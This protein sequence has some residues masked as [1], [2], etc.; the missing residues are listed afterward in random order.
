MRHGFVLAVVS[1]F[2]L[3]SDATAWAAAGRTSGHFAV[4]ASGSAQYSIPIWTP[5][6]IAGLEPSLA[7]QYSSRGGD[8]VYGV[9][10]SVAGF[11]SIGRC[12]KTYAQDGVT[13]A[14]EVTTGDLYCLDGN[15][16]RLVSGTYGA[17]GS[18]YQ[19]E[20]ADFS[21]VISHGT[22][23]TG[24]AWFEVRR[25]D[26]RIFEYGHTTDSLILVS[27]TTSARTWAL[28][29]ISDRVGNYIAFVYI[30]DTTNGVFRPSTITYVSSPASSATP[31]YQIKF[32]YQTRG[33]TPPSGFILGSPFEEPNL[34][35]Q[36]AVNA[37]NGSAYALERAYNLTYTTGSAS[38]RSRINTV[39]EC[40]S[41]DCLAPTTIGYQDGTVGFG[42]EN[43]VAGYNPGGGEIALDLN[44]DG[45]DDLI[46]PDPTSGHWY[47]LLG[48]AS[49]TYLGPYDTGIASTNS[50]TA[51]P[52][53]YNSDG[54][55]DVLVENAS[56]NWR[57][58][59]F[60]TAGGAFTYTD[61]STPATS[62]G[63]GMVIAG[64]VDGDGR[65]DLIYAVSGGK[66]YDTPDTIYY[67]LN[68]G[69][70]F[71]TTAYVLLNFPNNTT[72]GCESVCTKVGGSAGIGNNW[73]AFGKLA[74]RNR[75]HVRRADFNGDGR[76]DFLVF[77]QQCSTNNTDPQNCG[78]TY[79]IFSVDGIIMSQTNG[80][81]LLFTALRYQNGAT[82]PDWPVFGDFNG[83]GCTD[84]AYPYSGGYWTIRFSNCD[85]S[86]L[87][88]P[89]GGGIVTGVPYTT[90]SVMVVD[91]DGD[92]RDDL[93][94][95][96][97]GTSPHLGVIRS[98]GTGFSAWQDLGFAYLLA[99]VVDLNGDGQQD[100]LY[101]NKTRIHN[102]VATDLATSFTDGYGVTYSPS[103][104]PLSASAG[105][106]TKG[107]SQVFPQRD[108]QGP[109]YVVPSYTAS[110]GIGGT[111]TITNYYSDAVVNL[112]GRAGSWI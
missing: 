76:T 43:T 79:K 69:S 55:M 40:S 5:R 64:D 93:L 21:R 15:K 75:T 108:Y 95:A 103:Y 50:A 53:D 60:Q 88:S 39:T 72:N 94:V 102:G 63:D 24:P 51:I 7:L 25:K 98:T 44:G 35:S 89:L 67:R 20:I 6:G 42:T 37:W 92:G 38:G 99:D 74:Y 14:V 77:L 70:G 87:V 62:A 33:T 49:G 17:D 26:G 34:T 10:W 84:L 3:L 48:T 68:T 12:H 36:I 97:S 56:G 66:G 106:Y 52:I 16:L 13:D 112:Q 28:D 1:L 109:M 27:S 11:S 59:F 8:G 45:I 18:V 90:G 110:D 107:S 54:K 82:V 9:G 65:D 104:V 4:S 29:K 91:Y 30:N 80:T 46:Y 71:S 61:T 81:G 47:Y 105:A 73:P 41:T 83:D 96:G 2:A 58:L 101:S 111:Y 57:V 23:G 31:N 85:R 100:L 32:T 78:K 22:A 19:T 86:G